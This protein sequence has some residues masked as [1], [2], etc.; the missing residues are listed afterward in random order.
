MLGNNARALPITRQERDA[1][2]EVELPAGAYYGISTER[3]RQ[4]FPISGRTVGD[5]R[6]L[7]WAFG[8]VKAAAARA[9]E[10]TGLLTSRQSAAIQA[11]AAEVMDGAFDDQFVVDRIQGGAGTSTNMNANEVIA[12]RALELLGHEKGEYQHLDPIDHVNRSQSTNDAYP[13]AVK[14]AMRRALDDLLE[15]HS[16]LVT[17]FALKS[18]QFADILKIGRTQLQD[19]VPMTLGQEFGAF[20]ETLREDNDRMR[21]MRLHLAEVNLG[22]TAIGT[23]ITA[24]PAYRERVVPELAKITGLPL[25][26]AV[27]LVEA[28]SDTGVF[29]LLSGMIKRAA[30][31]LSKICNDLRLL[32]SGPQAGF[33]E[34]QLPAVQAGSSIMPGKVNPVIPEMVNQVAFRIV[35]SD[36][37]VTMAVEAGQLQLNAFEPVM[38]DAL[39]ESMEWLSHAC[40]TLRERCVVGIEANEDLLKQ[41]VAGSLAVITGLT[42]LLG[43][44][45]SAELAKEAMHGRR[46]LTELILERGLLAE[47][48]L[49]AAISPLNLTGV[50]T[51]Q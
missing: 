51:G 22:A 47:S 45:M 5:F 10:S 26:A 23:G 50:A 19:A 34:I 29:L 32:S 1:M 7:V 30:V 8:A 43:Y 17:A 9:N 15:E 38:A 40:K 49:T 36:M 21:E 16:M 37:T 12:N 11:A 14:I 6:H 44:A 33:G 2:G 27:N 31:K 18:S 48:E 42:P 28:T 39:L 3:A 4:N 20:S 35:G 25:V 41:R 46:S 24:S 13:T